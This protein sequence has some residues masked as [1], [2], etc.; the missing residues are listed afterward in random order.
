VAPFSPL[1]LAPFLLLTA[2]PSSRAAA[3]VAQATSAGA[4]HAGSKT[5]PS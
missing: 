1:A 5:V 2:S 3:T 4:H